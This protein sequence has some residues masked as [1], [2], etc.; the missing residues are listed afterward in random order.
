MLY[1]IGSPPPAGPKN[2]VFRIWSVNK[3]V[4][5]AADTSND[6]RNI[7]VISTDY[8]D[9]SIICIEMVSR[10]F[11]IDDCTNDIS[12]PRTKETPAKCRGEVMR[13]LESPV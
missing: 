10:W 5:P 3:R 4:I 8:T 6:N 7:A 1:I 11:C 2:I 9:N 12:L 13:S